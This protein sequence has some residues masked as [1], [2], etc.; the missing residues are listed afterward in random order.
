MSSSGNRG[1]LA[2]VVVIIIVIGIGAGYALIIFGGLPTTTTTNTTTTSSSTTTTSTTT[3]SV[4]T[5]TWTTDTLTTSWTGSTSVY[6]TTTTTTTVPTRILT[7]MTRFDVAVQG[8]FEP[9]FLAS[10]YAIENHIT[11]IIWKT[12]S[13]EFWDNLIDEGQVD[14]CWGGG[15]MLFEN[16]GSDDYLSPL[17]STK[18]IEVSERLN[19]TIAGAE[20]YGYDGNNDT[21]WLGSALSSFG[22]TVNHQF[23]DDHSLPTPQMWDD[24]GNTTFGSFLPTV[25][26]IGMGNAPST[27]SNTQIYQIISEVYGWE[28]GWD[29]LTR[30]AGNAQIYGGSV[31]TQIACENGDVGA[32]MSIDFYGSI[33]Q[34]R[35]PDCEYIVP[36]NET[37][38]ESEPIGIAST[39]VNK[40]LAEG[41]I[42]FV[43]SP[44]GQSL[45]LDDNLRR[46][47][48]LKEAFAQPLGLANPDMY[49]IYNQTITSNPIEFNYTLQSLT[50]YAFVSYFE[51]VFTNSHVE[52]VNCW[53]EI[54]DAFD[55]ALINGSEF[56][57]FTNKMS[58]LVEITD[59]NT[60]ENR[61]FTV[62]YATE[63]NTDLIYDA[64]YKAQVMFDW[65]TAAKAQY[66]A[67][68]TELLAYIA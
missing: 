48:V 18:M 1:L 41:F 23:L 17:N 37:I 32:S 11:D 12:P 39:S 4:P 42:D 16:L 45:L 15:Q 10:D 27:T 8:I 29:L 22:F 63:I 35:N 9:A 19:S 55:G 30:M 38:I 65:T 33:S 6:T 49:E 21:I 58:M 13:F 25:P 52:L 31:E 57:Y 7:V 54:V 2:V 34:L 5:T 50:N 53:K 26:T 51:S 43:V 44:Y 62:D 40:D 61:T 46:L 24:L 67:V 3:T 28:E 60:M 68:L 20:L 64:S 66:I 14:V 47:P 59:P 36:Q 56:E